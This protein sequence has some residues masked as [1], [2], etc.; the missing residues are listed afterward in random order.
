MQTCFIFV[1]HCEM[2]DMKEQVFCQ[3]VWIWEDSHRTLW[4][5]KLHICGWNL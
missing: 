3:I 4:N 5:T 1:S 2:A